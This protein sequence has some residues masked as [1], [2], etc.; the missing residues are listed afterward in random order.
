ML[1]L[2]IYWDNLGVDLVIV[3]VFLVEIILIKLSKIR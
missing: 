1:F 2:F 3:F